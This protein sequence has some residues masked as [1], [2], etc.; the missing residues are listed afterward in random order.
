MKAKLLF[1]FVTSLFLSGLWGCFSPKASAGSFEIDVDNSLYDLEEAEVDYADM[2]GYLQD[3]PPR[4]G[5]DSITCVRNLSLYSE[6]YRQR[7]FKMA[8]D[9]WRWVFLNCPL[10][11]QNI[12]IH[13]ANLVK[14]MYQNE[15]DPAKREALIDTLMMVYDQRIEYFNREGFIL[16]R[17]V[18]DLYQLRSDAAQ[19]HYDISEKSIQ[20]EG[21]AT[22]ADV[23]LINFQSTIRLTEAGILDASKVMENFD[24]AMDISDYNLIHNPS[25]SIYFIPAK[26]N[27]ESLFE[28]YAT[29]ESLVQIFTPR[30]KNNPS[31]PELLERITAMLNKAGCSD[32]DLFYLATKNLHRIN[33]TAQSAFMMGRMESSQENYPGAMEY[34]QQA[35]D[36]YED[37]SE[38]FTTYLLMA[39][40]SYQQQRRLA[41]AR[42]YALKASEIRPEDG[43]PFLLIGEMYAASARECGDNELTTKVAYWAA[44]DK[45]VQ[46]KNVDPD[47]V[48]KERATQLINTYSQYFPNGEIVF[49][50]GLS[51]GDPYR[52][53][54]W[55]NENTRVRGR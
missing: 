54:C 18:S 53:E 50:Y 40:I 17:K 27:I 28:P 19:E 14:F 1:L 24:R 10:A 4:Y 3:S 12:Y 25:D 51:E 26:N 55:I 34:Y 6:Y 9:S 21:N 45:F 5:E 30:F 31:D 52:V 20:I 38:M 7:N 39:N 13:G 29:C 36:L 35:I 41:Q 43:R 37:P 49:F 42:T 33:P 22:Q 16:G 2:T 47:P 8:T 15:T 23:L 48:V 11:T 46:A 44:V 32:T